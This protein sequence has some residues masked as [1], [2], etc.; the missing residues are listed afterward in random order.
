MAV[1]IVALGALRVID[2]FDERFIGGKIEAE[3]ATNLDMAR[4]LVDEG[5]T[6][7][8]KAL[9]DP[10]LARVND[11]SV[12]MTAF[13]LK[14]DIELGAG[15]R[16]EAVQ[17]LATAL[18]RFPA[19]PEHPE[20]SL[21]YARLLE[22]SGQTDEAV[23]LYTRLRESAPP[24]HRG[25]AISGLARHAEREGK[26]QVARDLYKLAVKES[27]WGSANWDEAAE[28]LGRLNVAAIFSPQPTPDSKV[29]RV[30]S[31][32]TLT[33]IGMKLNTTQGLL[34]RANRITDPTALRI[35]Q[36]LKYTPKDFKIII[37]RST[38]RLFLMDNEGLF[39]VY[40]VGLGKPGQDTT[41]GR[42]RIGNKEKDP[43]WHKP[44]FGP[45]P[46]GDPRNELGTRWMPLIPEEEGLPTD[47]GIHGTIE[48]ETV[49][50][51]TSMGCPR[52][53]PD[54]VEE[55]FDLVV[56]S[57]PVT[58]VEKFDPNIAL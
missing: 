33:G 2:W 19:A 46:P 6:A 24:A 36:N 14:A 50:K 5:N 3:A 48:P 34:M 8:A 53:L 39:K 12:T 25:G 44:G 23:A 41:L 10:I 1:G 47:L 32:D 57:T 21:K 54:E 11:P 45:I 15:N 4:Q 37:E 20:V 18:E 56:R 58:I 52:L 26:T 35:N 30:A 13:V 43:T 7:E 49:G 55:L 28:G 27:P 51:Y 31:G 9:L 40:K 38:L 17:T 29:Y 22:E 16:A 42:Y